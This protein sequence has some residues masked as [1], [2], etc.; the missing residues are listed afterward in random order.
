MKMNKRLM[1]LVAVAFLLLGSYAYGGCLTVVSPNGGE[2]WP[3][4]TSHNI[5]WSSSC[6]PGT[7]VKIILRK[8]GAYF[9]KIAT[10]I[11][12]SQAV[13]PWT[14]GN[15]QGG[16]APQGSD[17]KILVKTMDNAA[18]DA[19][20]ADFSISNT[21]LPAYNDSGGLHLPPP[22]MPVPLAFEPD[23]EIYGT[24]LQFVQSPVNLVKVRFH[25]AIRNAGKADATN[26]KVKL[27]ITGPA[28]STLNNYSE[29]STYPSLPVGMSLTYNR[30]FNILTPGKYYFT[31]IA[32]PD[33]SISEIS[34]NNNTVTRN[35]TVNAPDLIVWLLTPDIYMSIEQVISVGVLNIGTSASPATQLVVEIEGKG[36]RTFIV[37]TLGPCEFKI[38]DRK[39][40]FYTHLDKWIKMGADPSNNMRELRKG[41]N[42]VRTNL[43]IHALTSGFN[44]SGLVAP[45]VNLCLQH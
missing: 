40:R 22:K 23:F 9:G 11:P 24:T 33:N 19:S 15:Y 2:V 3:P 21:G 5:R 6:L 36:T 25:T 27:K 8:G 41:N 1:V 7:N 38:F 28:G 12:A 13:H 14:V 4:G 39:E 37:P 16:T 30:T 20:D 44:T 32:D 26:I 35:I 17:Y 29:T 43:N 31:L 42:N 45:P 34:E 18:R 10:N